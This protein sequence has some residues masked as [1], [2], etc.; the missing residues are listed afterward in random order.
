MVFSFYHL[1]PDYEQQGAVKGKWVLKQPD[2]AQFRIILFD[3]QMEMQKGNSWNAVFLNC[4][5][6]PRSVSHFGDDGSCRKESAKALAPMIH[7]L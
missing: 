3:W 4:H 5:D 2:G 6:Q 7:M 1:K